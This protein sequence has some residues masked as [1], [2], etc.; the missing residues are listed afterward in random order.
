MNKLLT[1]GISLG[2][3]TTLLS[4]SVSH[5][6][7]FADILGSHPHYLHARSDLRKADRL[8]D[9]RYEPNVT[10]KLRSALYQDRLAIRD[11]DVASI[12]DGKNLDD[13]PPIDSSLKGAG[14]LHEVLR[15]LRSARHDLE[16]PESN[17]SDFSWR[18]RAFNHIDKSIN[19]VKEAI[20]LKHW[21]EQ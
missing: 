10:Q 15:L 16:Y 18:D 19:D 6:P 13:H 1:R 17:V 8:L 11:I 21:D 3:I 9:V 14:R 2:F 7:A 4:L 5:K 20:R 12:L